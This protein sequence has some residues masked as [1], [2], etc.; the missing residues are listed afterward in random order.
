M[1]NSKDT[2][3]KVHQLPSEWREI[4]K[5]YEADG[6]LGM[7]KLIL[8]RHSTKTESPIY[9]QVK[10]AWKS[11][12]DKKYNLSTDIGWSL[13]HKDL[14]AALIRETGIRYLDKEVQTALCSDKHVTAMDAWD[15]LTKRGIS[16]K[17]HNNINRMKGTKS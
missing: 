10:K 16:K 8:K 17:N 6:E 14:K 3:I 15:Y 4:Y 2:E 11:C 12:P 1:Q 9:T 7:C 13:L 5:R